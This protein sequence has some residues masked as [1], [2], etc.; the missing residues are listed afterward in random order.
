MSADYVAAQDPA[1]V[2]GKIKSRAYWLIHVRPVGYKPA[3]FKTIGRCREVAEKSTVVLRGWDYPHS[4]RDGPT[5]KQDHV[6]GWVDWDAHKELWR[7]YQSG[8]FIHFLGL[9]EDWYE[10][11]DWLGPV[12]PEIKPGQ[13][14]EPIHTVLTLTE[15]FEYIARLARLEERIFS[16]GAEVRIILRKASGRRLHVLDPRRAPMFEEYQCAAEEVQ[17][18]QTLGEKQL[19]EDN[20]KL[21]ISSTVEIMARFQWLT[22]PIAVFEDVQQRLYD[23]RL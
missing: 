5:V 1:S 11:A 4:P 23:K 9:R 15:V 14:L 16:E 17:S 6:E 10:E 19:S 12:H 13:I 3:Q 18:A 21:A 2:L 22:P 7:L 20:R 8:Q